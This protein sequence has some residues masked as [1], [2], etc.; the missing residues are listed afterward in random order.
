MHIP[1]GL[2]IKILS[3]YL[4][5]MQINSPRNN[6]RLYQSHSG[7]MYH[8]CT[9]ARVCAR[10][11]RLQRTCTWRVLRR[12]VRR[13]QGDDEHTCTHKLDSKLTTAPCF[14]PKWIENNTRK[15]Q[16]A[17]TWI[18]YSLQFESTSSSLACPTL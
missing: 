17:A 4:V 16:Y 6:G 18:G 10:P 1:D 9:R 14:F 7:T 2:A 11:H 5:L 8:V 15:S 13:T 3:R 12:H